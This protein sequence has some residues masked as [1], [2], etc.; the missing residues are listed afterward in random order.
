VNGALERPNGSG[1]AIMKTPCN[2]DLLVKGNFREC[3]QDRRYSAW[4]ANCKNE[5]YLAWSQPGGRGRHLGGQGMGENGPMSL[6]R[7]KL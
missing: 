2:G 5:S 3:R 4:V 7:R 6:L 1:G